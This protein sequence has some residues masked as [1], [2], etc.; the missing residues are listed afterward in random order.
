MTL[1]LRETDIN[2]LLDMDACISAL[3]AA[4]LDQRASLMPRH[5]LRQPG[6]ILQLMAASLP[7]VGFA[8][9]KSYSVAKGGVRFMVALYLIEDGQLACIMEADQL[10][11]TRTGAA[12]ALAARYL[13]P[14]GS[15]RLGLIGTG[16]QAQ[17]QFMG[18]SRVRR[19]E[20]ARVYGRDPARRQEF[21][22]RMSVATG[23]KVGA[24]QTAGEAV[25]GADVVVT[26]TAAADPVIQERD[27]QGVKLIIAM[28]SNSPVHQELAVE[29]VAA[30]SLVV[31]DSLDQ[32]MVEC[33]DLI[34]ADRAGQFKWDSATELTRVVDGS[35]VATGHDRILFE[36]QGLA[37]WDVAAAALVYRRALEA[38]MGV[39]VE[40]L[41]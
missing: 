32:A 2:K 41:E 22:E 36:S 26:A 4:H 39:L 5:R 23:I 16:G 31:V 15:I 24:V 9:F 13:A 27:L 19:I 28:G 1:L 29:T 21:A 3:E 40:G 12:S 10:G 8:G 25:A 37:L 20:S 18:I 35:I 38:Q 17:T 30:C 11:R 34:A 6:F 33:G 14:P 7:S